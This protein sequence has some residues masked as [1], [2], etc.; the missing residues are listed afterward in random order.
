[1]GRNTFESIGVPLPGR[2]NLVISKNPNFHPEGV[3]VFDSVEKAVNFAK[4]RDEEELMVIGGESIYTSVL[5]IADTIYLTQVSGTYEG[6][7]HFPKLAE[8]NW[9]T[10]SLEHHSNNPDFEFRHLERR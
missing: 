2:T 7:A 4:S 1:M 10:I 6:N 3:I 8:E 9:V 5:P